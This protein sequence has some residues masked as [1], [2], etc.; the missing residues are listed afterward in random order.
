MIETTLSPALIALIRNSERV[1]LIPHERPDADALGATLGLARALTTAG[2]TA[3]VLLGEFVKESLAFLPG[4]ANL[5]LG[6]SAEADAFLAAADLTLVCDTHEPTLLGRWLEPLKRVIARDVSAVAVIDHHNPKGELIFS[7]GWIDP[8]YSSTCEMMLLALERLGWPLDT[9][10]ASDL[11]AGVMFDT[12]RFTNAN[13]QPR[14]LTNAAKL[15]EH[16]AD[17]ADINGKLF[18][19]G[20]PA[21]VQLRGEV[22]A[23]IHMGFEGRYVWVA[24][25]Q[26]QLDRL[27]LDESALTGF[28]NDLRLIEGVKVAAVLYAT[29]PDSTRA[30]LR[31]RDGYEVRQIAEQ[32]PA[33]GGHSV[34][35]GC[36]IPLPL[37]Q[38]AAD[39]QQKIATLFAS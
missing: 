17:V 21:E 25:T 35:A 5:A 22:Y 2:K 34:A 14:T 3:R 15:V 31:S 18:S 8:S 29:Q 1:A 10:I 13:T 27:G 19:L 33:G 4:F 24:V 6:H 23:S 16:G 9:A 7:Q 39:L 11:M 36:Q 28:S 12:S 20:T 32:Y 26:A 38:A 37:E 30:S